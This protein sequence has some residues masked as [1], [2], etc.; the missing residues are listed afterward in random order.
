MNEQNLL[1]FSNRTESEQ[2]EIAK[3]GGKK[4]GEARRQK[5][6]LREFWQSFLFSD[7]GGKTGL[8][9]LNEGL[10]KRVIEKGDPAAY[11]KVMEY[12]GLSVNQALK[13]EEQ[14]FRR[15]ELKLK[16]AELELKQ[17]SAERK[18]ENPGA[19]VLERMVKELYERSD[20]ETG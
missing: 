7:F 14:K 10:S 11:E 9:L 19:S 2:R 13:E 1:P 6:E 4:S 5:K 15:E 17:A 3:K 8:E 20:G 12:A 18:D 16:K